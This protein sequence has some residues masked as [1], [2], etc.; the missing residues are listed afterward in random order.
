M[1]PEPGD[2]VLHNLA[3]QASQAAIDASG[4]GECVRRAG[5]F[6]LDTITNIAALNHA[7]VIPGSASP[8]I[9]DAAHWFASRQ[10]G[11]RLILRSPADDDVIAA[12]RAAGYEVALDRP[13][14][15][16]P[17]P[18]G[19]WPTPAG[20][21]I[22]PVVDAR[23]AKLHLAARD[24][25]PDRPPDSTEQ[26]FILRLSAGRRFRYVTAFREGVP[27]GTAMA[28]VEGEFASISN[29]FVREEER[30]RGLGAA[31]TAAAAATVAG[32]RS[33][34]LEASALGEPVYRRMGFETRSR[35]LHL[36]LPARSANAP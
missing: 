18:L 21:T 5:W 15:A 28:F 16:R 1:P 6:L 31:L 36:A 7:R 32:A 10:A 22:E 34:V 26:V 4:E 33:F 23:T 25:S 35:I 29:L 20:V 30:N 19:E 8:R 2:D 14:M 27:V 12:A 11:F 24:K 3:I 17:A 13:L 9:E